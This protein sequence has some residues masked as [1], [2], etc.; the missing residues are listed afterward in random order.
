MAADVKAQHEKAHFE[1]QVNR[2]PYKWPNAII[3]GAEIKALAQSPADWVVNQIVDGPGEDP[4]V[5]DGQQIDLS[6]VGIEKFITRKPKT[7][8]G[9]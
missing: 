3:T 2:K 1:I 9:A 7:T 4:E 8:P 6:T 5:A